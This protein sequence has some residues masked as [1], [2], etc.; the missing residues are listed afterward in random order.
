LTDKPSDEIGRL[1]AALEMFTEAIE[2]SGGCVV[3]EF[4]NAHP[5]AD[6]KWTDVGAAY[7][8]ACD[9]LGVIPLAHARKMVS[10]LTFEIV[11][12]DVWDEAGI[13]EVAEEFSRMY[14]GNLNIDSACLVSAETILEPRKEEDVDLDLE[15]DEGDDDLGE[16]EEGRE[17]D[18]PP[19]NARMAA[20]A[21]LRA[22]DREADHLRKRLGLHKPGAL[23]TW[24]SDV[25]GEREYEV[26]A[27][28]FGRFTLRKLEGRN[29]LDRLALEEAAYDDEEAARTAARR[30][31]KFGVDWDA[32]D[33]PVLGEDD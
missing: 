18:L 31:G 24:F 26:E 1:R 17:G 25:S 30:L 28:G 19:G 10:K 9:T 20:L 12:T 2:A 8:V 3:D 11:T 23:V 27:D 22:L 6:P 21:R 13:C 16:H 4:G 5:A 29:P 32:R 33:T 15:G 7:I 14:S